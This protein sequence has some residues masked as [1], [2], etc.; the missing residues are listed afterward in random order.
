MKLTLFLD[1]QA[2]ER[3]AQV[4]ED[5][6]LAALRLF[7]NDDAS[8]RQQFLRWDREEDGRGER[9]F[10]LPDSVE[11]ATLMIDTR[12]T[13]GPS[14]E[15]ARYSTLARYQLTF[16]EMRPG[17]LYRG[18]FYDTSRIWKKPLV[19]GQFRATLV[20]R[21]TTPRNAEQRA[22]V[23]RRRRSAD[24]RALEALL[25]AYFQQING[26]PLLNEQLR[27]M[28]VPVFPSVDVN[29][30]PASMF[31]WLGNE[32][33]VDRP[34][35][36]QQQMQAAL[37]LVRL[38][39]RRYIAAVREAL[40]RRSLE[41]SDALTMLHAST[42]AFTLFVNSWD[43]A[44]DRGLR[45]QP[46]ERF[47][48]GRN[49]R[50]AGD[51]DDDGKEAA[52][53]ANQ[54]RRM[55]ASALPSGELR[56]LHRLMR[57][58]V[59]IMVTGS[60]TSPQAQHAMDEQQQEQQLGN[61]IYGALVPTDQFFSMLRL[62]NE[63]YTRELTAEIAEKYPTAPRGLRLPLL[64]LEGTNFSDGIVDSPLRFT[65][66][67]SR[68]LQQQRRKDAAVAVAMQRWGVP[69]LRPHYTLEIQIRRENYSEDPRKVPAAQFSSFYRHPLS[70]WVDLR[71]LHA[72]DGRQFS[73]VQFLNQ[74]TNVYAVDIRELAAQSSDVRIEPTLF[75]S[76]D[77]QATL[78]RVLERQERPRALS[79]DL[80][81][82]RT[83]PLAEN[84]RYA[85]DDPTV[86]Q[87]RARRQPPPAL[88]RYIDEV[89]RRD[90]AVRSVHQWHTTFYRSKLNHFALHVLEIQL[91][92]D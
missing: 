51:C 61:H 54:F 86:V 15:D 28:F 11:N 9:T 82:K 77:E 13:T 56:A 1:W 69:R 73:D 49:E 75:Y 62:P 60:V 78:E 6:R 64:V 81:D 44:A 55:D 35:F 36:Y 40:E 72:L 58:Y 91:N 50:G 29:P 89:I 87:F 68:G 70:A 71:D 88:Q 57:H 52:F 23:Q 10:E 25:A 33:V 42:L 80:G 66:E 74:R 18:N 83:L 3:E 76:R 46:S 47:L 7:Y 21:E 4:A 17:R 22:L 92:V 41:G 45:K 5:E 19:R 27:Q 48:V 24:S 79:A 43:Y 14:P 8:Q 16:A 90:P 65:R 20:A 26:R 30:L 63:L 84:P 59:P 32:R 38:P 85:A 31:H 67:K 12:R 53:E 37:A 2:V 34:G 39:P